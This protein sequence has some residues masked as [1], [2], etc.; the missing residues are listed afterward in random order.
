MTDKIAHLP[1]RCS[2][3]ALDALDQAYE[4][5]QPTSAPVHQAGSEDAAGYVPYF[6]A[7]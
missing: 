1:A 5:F 6:D 2:N 3:Q 4:Y 7:A